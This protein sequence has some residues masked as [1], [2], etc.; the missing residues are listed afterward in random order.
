M[1]DFFTQ[2]VLSFR[3]AF[4]VLLT[5]VLLPPHEEGCRLDHEIEQR[6]SDA[7]LVRVL[8][9]DGTDVTGQ[10]QH[11]ATGEKRRFQGLGELAQAIADMRQGDDEDSSRRDMDR[12]T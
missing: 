3:D 11:I 2:A 1:S 7:F 4:D 12:D 10:I 6:R 5:P 9:G 8:A